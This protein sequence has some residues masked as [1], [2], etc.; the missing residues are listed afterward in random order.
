MSHQVSPTNRGFFV[1]V[2]PLARLG[3]IPMSFWRF[4]PAAI[5]FRKKDETTFSAPFSFEQSA[6]GVNP[7]WT[8]IVLDLNLNI[9]L[10][11]KRS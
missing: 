5:L 2:S 1:P 3:L 11:D 6:D 7:N 8:V 10:P 4:V 9:S